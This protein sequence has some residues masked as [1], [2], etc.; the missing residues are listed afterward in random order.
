MVDAVD[1]V[2]ASGDAGVV[3]RSDQASPY[4]CQDYLAFRAEHNF[5]IGESSRQLFGRCSRRELLVSRKPG[6][7]QCSGFSK[8]KPGRCWTFRDLS[9]PGN[10]CLGCWEY[11]DLLDT[12]AYA[13]ASRA[14]ETR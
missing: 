2:A 4:G 1:D 5:A 10:I 7:V 6:A 14:T 8:A 11:S 12:A 3:V 13:A 9:A